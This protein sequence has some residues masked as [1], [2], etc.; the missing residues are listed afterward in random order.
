MDAI[1][2]WALKISFIALAIGGVFVGKKFLSTSEETV[3][4]EVV[5]DLIKDELGVTINLTG[6]TTGTPESEFTKDI[7]YFVEDGLNK[8]DK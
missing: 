8:L 7:V 1:L 3:V 6:D 4:E 5:Q 2:G